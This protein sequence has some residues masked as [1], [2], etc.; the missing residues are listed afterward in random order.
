M[1]KNICLFAFILSLAMAVP[2]MAAGT[3]TT[4][5]S[6]LTVVE[7]PTLEDVQIPES[8]AAA[9]KPDDGEANTADAGAG[10]VVEVD[11]HDADDGEANAADAGAGIVIDVNAHDAEVDAHDTDI[12]VRDTDVNAH[13]AEV[14]AHD[15]DID[16]HDADVSD[17]ASP[18][19]N[20]A[21]GAWE[22]KGIEGEWMSLPGLSYNYY[23][24]PDGTV[25]NTDGSLQLPVQYSDDG[26]FTIDT[27]GEEELAKYTVTGRISTIS[28][29][30]MD[31]FN[32]KKDTEYLDFSDDANQLILTITYPDPKN[33]LAASPSVTNVYL[34]RKTNQ[35]TVIKNFITDKVWKSGENTLKITSDGLLDLNDGVSTGTYSVY[36]DNDSPLYLASRVVFRWDN[37]G[38]VKY[39]PVMISENS[40]HLQNIDNPDEVLAFENI[41]DMAVPDPGNIE[42]FI[43]KWGITKI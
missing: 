17:P 28:Q 35:A 18:I 34:L 26:S 5:S 30:S 15:T 16:A 22:R 2:C 12:E 21:I 36:E 38:T 37:G 6:G 10:I 4:A 8:D 29:E 3:D 19:I 31:R 20:P 41:K 39:A 27:S 11:A 24:Y 1:K 9:E 32:V 33:P 13:D 43:G 42:P 25:T 7:I 14:D 40:I 23:I